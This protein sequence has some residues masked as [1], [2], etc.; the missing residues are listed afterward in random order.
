[1]TKD[2]TYQASV[3]LGSVVVTVPPKANVVVRYRADAGSVTAFGRPVV[4]G[5]ELNGTV[6][7]PQPMRPKQPTLT[8]D[9][10]VDVGALEVRR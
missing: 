5:T 3:D 9:L 8:L 10:G 7:D 2:A 4:N 1:M 6:S